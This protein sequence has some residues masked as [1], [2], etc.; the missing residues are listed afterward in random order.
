MLCANNMFLQEAVGGEKRQRVEEVVVT[1]SNDARF[2]ISANTIVTI[3]TTFNL[4]IATLFTRNF[5]ILNPNNKF[6]LPAFI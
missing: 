5:T 2:I 6:L 4:S 3:I 1:R